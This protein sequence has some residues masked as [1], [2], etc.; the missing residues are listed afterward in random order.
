MALAGTAAATAV[1]STTVAVTGVAIYLSCI[2]A[3]TLAYAAS[4]IAMANQPD[5]TRWYQRI[6][7]NIIRKIWLLTRSSPQHVISE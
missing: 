5:L 2:A 1:A 6:S 3:S 7:G 4:R